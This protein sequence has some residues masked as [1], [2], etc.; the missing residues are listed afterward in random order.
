MILTISISTTT[1]QLA[2]KRS[3]NRNT[4]YKPKAIGIPIAFFSFRQVSEKRQ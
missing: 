2:Q 1:A 3:R 4:I